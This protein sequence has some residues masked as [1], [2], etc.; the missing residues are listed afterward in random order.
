MAGLT[1][2]KVDLL[3]WQTEQTWAEVLQSIE[4]VTEHQAWGVLPHGS[5]EYLHTDGS[6]QGIVLHL[7]TCKIMMGSCGFR[8]T[9]RRWRDL[10]DELDS[11]EPS[12]EASRAYLMQAHDYWL[13]CLAGIADEDLDQEVSNVHG[14]KS[15]AKRMITLVMY[16]DA[17]HAGQIAAVRYAAAESLIPPPKQA[18]D[19]RAHCADLPSW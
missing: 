15:L 13:T 14:T 19:I 4:G 18:D 6:V 17:Y 10:A 9:E 2:G 7:A 16:H 5:E 1:H 3:K 12:W 8:G 11:F